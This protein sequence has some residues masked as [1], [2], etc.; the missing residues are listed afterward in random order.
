M[1]QVNGDFV[2][3]IEATYPPG[4]DAAFVYDLTAHYIFQAS[5]AGRRMPSEPREE[6][7]SG[8]SGS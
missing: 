1:K 8:S 6:S 5:D 3:R 2:H 7:D 4:A